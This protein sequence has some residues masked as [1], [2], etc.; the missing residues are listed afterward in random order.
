[1]QVEGYK[2]LKADLALIKH[3]TQDLNNTIEH[4]EHNVEDVHEEKLK[5]NTTTTEEKKERQKQE[6]EVTAEEKEI[7]SSDSTTNTDKHESL[8]KIKERFSAAV[9]ALSKRDQLKAQ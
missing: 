8:E 4:T 5:D 9:E 1:M 2:P 7:E 6:Q 3:I